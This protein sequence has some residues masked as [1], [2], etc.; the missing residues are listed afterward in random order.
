M[1]NTNFIANGIYKFAATKATPIAL[2]AI[3]VTQLGNIGVAKAACSEAPQDQAARVLQPHT[4]KAGNLNRA[5]LSGHR[6]AKHLDQ[7][8][9]AA[10]VLDKHYR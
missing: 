10:R 1:P 7:Q 5:D 9:Q 6:Q 2:M 3:L 4:P 8:L